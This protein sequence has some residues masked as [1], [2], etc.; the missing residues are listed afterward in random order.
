LIGSTKPFSPEQLAS[1]YPT[2]DAYVTAV[3]RAATGSVKA[4]F[5]L[6]HDA[7]AIVAAAERSNVGQA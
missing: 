7:D 4:G 3:R 2:H 6:Q 1:R 5:L